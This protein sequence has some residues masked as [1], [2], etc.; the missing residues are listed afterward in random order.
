MKK[1]IPVLVILILLLA[2]T[3]YAST[4]KETFSDWYLAVDYES[5]GR[6]KDALLLYD[7]LIREKSFVPAMQIRAAV[8]SRYGQ[9]DEAVKVLERA[10]EI[11]PADPLIYKKLA[12]AYYASGKY[13]KA[14]EM[15]VKYSAMC[16]RDRMA[17]ALKEKISKALGPEFYRTKSAAQRQ[18]RKELR[19]DVKRFASDDLPAVRVAIAQ[20]VKH[21]ELKV[22]S[23]FS[24]LCAGNICFSGKA[25]VLYDI[26][27]STGR[28]LIKQGN[29][30]VAEVTVPFEVHPLHK[31]GVLGIFNVAYGHG[32]HWAGTLNS[33]F[34]GFIR[35]VKDGNTI[36]VIDVVNIEEYVYGVLPSEIP[37]GWPG[38]TLKAQAVL[39]RTLAFSRKGW[40][41]KKGYDFE[42]ST[43]TQVYLGVRNETDAVIDAVEQ[44]QGIVLVYENKPAQ[45]YFCS[46]SGG[47]TVHNGF[48]MKYYDGV[49]DAEKGSR[50][51]SPITED[52][53]FDFLSPDFNSFSN[54]EGSYSN[55]FRWQR[56]IFNSELCGFLN[57]SG[58]E[59][60]EVK[61]IKVTARNISGHAEKVS[62]MT[63]RAVY[64]IDNELQIRKVL[65]NLRSSLFIVEKVPDV[66]NA[67]YGFLFWGGGYGHGVGMSQCGA[68]GMAD[69]G[70]K[71]QQ[72]LRHYYP[73]LE[74][75]KAY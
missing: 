63:D 50:L 4:L 5:Q 34:R 36:T 49:L 48:G 32:D 27:Y 42:N 39:A 75:R 15:I 29:S 37:A 20:G 66:P 59:C 70:Y 14:S 12:V 1:K 38:E 53:L 16:P 54:I 55:T 45:I 28:A 21:F 3:L 62:I 24:V 43:Q 23:D 51:S 2:A 72:I 68:R 46:N 73:A 56:F 8:Y 19:A 7:K 65:G 33:F 6:A 47:H 11:D 9:H 67:P 18:E 31:K 30:I 57:D 13:T 40:R 71:W 64:S 52:K 22:M 44:T 60:S 41:S 17:G 26:E 69:K 10:K 25:D 35:C 74:L 61:D 58:Y